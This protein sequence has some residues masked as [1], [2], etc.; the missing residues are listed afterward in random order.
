MSSPARWIVQSPP[1]GMP[2]RRRR[3]ICGSKPTSSMRS[4]SSRVRTAARERDAA[5]LD[6]VD[7][8]AGRRDEQVAAAVELAQLVAR[9]GAAVDDDRPHA[10]Q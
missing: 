8:P 7:E 4:A 9:L 1:C 10:L 3:R 6:Q 5:A 2:S